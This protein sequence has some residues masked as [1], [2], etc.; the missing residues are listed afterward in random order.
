[1]VS[2]RTKKLYIATKAISNQQFYQSGILFEKIYELY[3]ADYYLY[4]NK[5]NQDTLLT[6]AQFYAFKN[7]IYLKDYKVSY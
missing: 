1:M 5:V 6:L 4:Y 2:K 3:K 7:Y